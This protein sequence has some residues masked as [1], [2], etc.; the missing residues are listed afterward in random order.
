MGNFKKMRFKK[1]AEIEATFLNIIL[2]VVILMFL[3]G[4]ITSLIGE[5]HSNYGDGLSEIQINGLKNLTD[6]SKQ[7]SDDLES[8][9]AGES[10]NDGFLTTMKN[11]FTGKIL[12]FKTVYQVYKSFFNN[13][14]ISLGINPNSY[15]L[16]VVMVGISLFVLVIIGLIILKIFI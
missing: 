1:K 15:L 4:G 7:M 5:F 10:D 3:I 11:L 16:T 6:S 14:L 8:G 13:L 12:S 2:G 9:L